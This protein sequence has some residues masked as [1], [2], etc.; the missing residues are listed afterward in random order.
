MREGKIHPNWTGLVQRSSQS[1]APENIDLKDN[2]F[3]PD[4]EEYPRETT[5]HNPSVAPE[6]VT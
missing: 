5:S 4:I 3:I 2:W 6:N 1:V